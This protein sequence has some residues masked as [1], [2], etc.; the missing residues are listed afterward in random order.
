MVR[1]HLD[2]NERSAIGL[3]AVGP[4]AVVLTLIALSGCGRPT[5]PKPAVLPTPVHYNDMGEPSTG[6]AEPLVIPAA[7][8]PR[9]LVRPDQG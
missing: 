2:R 7:R 1:R 6:P 3:L 4:L 9:P 5:P 8:P